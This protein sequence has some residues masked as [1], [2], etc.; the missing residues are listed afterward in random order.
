MKKIALLTSGGD[1]PG[2]NAAI[3]A[4][5]RLALSNDIKVY[6]IEKGYE[7]LLDKNFKE[8]TWS[9]V[10][11]IIFHGGTIL[12]TARCKRFLED[13]WVD[14][15]AENLKEFGID[16][17]FTIGGDGTLYGALELSKRGITVVGIPATIDNDLGYT[18]LCIGFDSCINNAMD[19]INKIRDTSSSHQRATIIEV[20]GRNCG[21]VALYAGLAAGADAILIPECEFSMQ[22]LI[23]SIREGQ[24]HGRIHTLIVKAEGVDIPLN[25]LTDMIE[26]LTG[27]ETRAVVPGYILRGGSPTVRDRLFASLCAAKAME[28][29]KDQ[30]GAFTVGLKNN[31]PIILPLDEAL[32]VKKEFR[33][34][35]YQLAQILA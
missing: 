28:I 20:M 21:D 30:S 35:I 29:T 13:K 6:G 3:R 12:K 4:I 9:D 26:K 34:D 18:D 31:K 17:L 11:G 32:S 22:G 16:A 15:A 19:I 33:K 10:G 7:G 2:M 1:A 27:Q 14:A 25:E 5:V 8:M 23:D 24:K